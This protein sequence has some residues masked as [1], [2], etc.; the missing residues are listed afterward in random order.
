MKEDSETAY[1]KKAEPKNILL[2]KIIIN[3][4]VYFED[5]IGLE[6]SFY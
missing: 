3:L 5:F 4:F 2:Y 6:G 1:L